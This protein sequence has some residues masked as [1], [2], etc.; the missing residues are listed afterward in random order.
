MPHVQVDGIA[1][2]Y[3]Q[4]GSGDPVVFIHGAFIGNAFGPLID[5]PNLSKRCQLITYHRRGYGGSSP[6]DQP[7]SCE[8]QAADCHA[9]L[10]ALRMPRAHVVGHSFGGSIAL[11][12]AL[13]APDVVA[14]LVLLE[15]ALFTG[16]SAA[17]Y[18]ESLVRSS[19][20]YMQR[21]VATVMEEFFL[22][23]WPAYSRAELERVLPGSFE[24]ALV[25]ARTTFEVDIGL[26]D[27]EFGPELARL[28][29]Q[30]TL[31]VLGGGS[32]ALHP[33]FGDTYRSLLEWLPRAEGLVV[34]DATHFFQ[35]ESSATAARLADALVRFYEQ[36]PLRRS[37]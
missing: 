22:A 24:Q 3:H 5:Q 31:V 29:N 2:E 4:S 27:W 28:I 16:A 7:I 36:H 33:R 19:Q 37:C 6:L 17:S 34:A 13:Q 14:S 1:I 32:E 26:V 15:P 10:Q 23:R 21:G 12:L 18:R 30:P 11:Q 35:L 9:V 20:T 8:R 25:D